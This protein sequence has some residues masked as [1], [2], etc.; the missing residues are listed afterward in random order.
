MMLEPD[1]LDGLRKMASA[2]RDVVEMAHWLLDQLSLDAARDRIYVIAYL[3][4]TYFLSAG[5]A[6][7]IGAWSLF[8]GGTW[9]DEEI[10]RFLSPRI[11]STRNKWLMMH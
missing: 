11:L 7:A 1:L 5:D 9:S 3:Q 2:N 8:P 10:E 6:A 4:Q